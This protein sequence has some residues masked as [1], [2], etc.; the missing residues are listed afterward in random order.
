VENQQQRPF[1]K[2][3]ARNSADWKQIEKEKQDSTARQSKDKFVLHRILRGTTH[4]TNT[5]DEE[6]QNRNIK[7]CF[8]VNRYMFEAL[9]V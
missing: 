8:G 3:K 9:A 7:G 4:S 1:P 2:E 6:R 5:N